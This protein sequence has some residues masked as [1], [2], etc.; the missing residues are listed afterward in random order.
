M[1]LL[2]IGVVLALLLPSPQLDMI[3]RILFIGNSITLTMPNPE[4]G[5]FLSCGATVT[6]CD[7][8]YVHRLQLGI[9]ARQGVIPEIRIIQTGGDLYPQG[10][11]ETVQEW[12]PDLIIFQIGDN[13]PPEPGAWLEQYAALSEAAEGI[14]IVAVGVWAN[15][16]PRDGYI[17]QAARNAGMIYARISDLHTEDT[18]A[19]SQC[20]AEFC[21]AGLYWHPG[22]EG[23]TMIAGR[24]LQALQPS[25]YFPFI[26]NGSG[27]TIP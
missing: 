13:A 4:M 25:T 9:A 5:W 14:K 20:E 12:Q 18:E 24:I 22:N 7:L 17:Q 6:Q 2:S 27:G 1:V 11:L 3:D 16:D 15:D 10:T 26:A 23:M 21:H 8:D 19:W